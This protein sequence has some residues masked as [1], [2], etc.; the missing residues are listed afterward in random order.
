MADV[1]QGNYLFNNPLTVATYIK[2]H[3]LVED[4][5]E[6][7][8]GRELALRELNIIRSRISLKVLSMIT[9]ILAF[10]IINY[11]LLMTYI[12]SQRKKIVVWLIFG[13]SFWERHGLFLLSMIGLTLLAFT[14]V[15]LLQLTTFPIILG[16]MTLDAFIY[17]G[18]LLMCENKE[19]LATIKKGN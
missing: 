11:F 13:K 16:L 10:I 8:S 6:L 7:T 14:V 1:S 19:C 17:T 2:D 12:E 15:F 18:L 9:S 3:G 5:A 4:F